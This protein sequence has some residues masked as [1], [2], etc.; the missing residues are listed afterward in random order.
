MMP[1]RSKLN[2]TL[3]ILLQYASNIHKLGGISCLICYLGGV[4]YQVLS[5]FFKFKFTFKTIL[6]STH[7]QISYLFSWD[8]LETK[9]SLYAFILF[10]LIFYGKHLYYFWRS[11]WK[12]FRNPLNFLRDVYI[13]NCRNKLCAVVRS[14]D[15]AMLLKPINIKQTISSILFVFLPYEYSLSKSWK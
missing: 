2:Q 11:C 13:S 7:S 10:L 4:R 12:P 14:N 5:I 1:G 15:F 8:F 3:Y 6:F 9:N